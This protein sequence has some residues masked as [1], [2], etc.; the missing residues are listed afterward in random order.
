MTMKKASNQ[1]TKNIPS[2]WFA[3]EE[4]VKQTASDYK[5]R[6]P[7]ANNSG[8]T[9]CGGGRGN[10]KAGLECVLYIW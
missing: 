6:I 8:L 1:I 9:G 7:G 4:T 10:K 3:L 2:L 5:I